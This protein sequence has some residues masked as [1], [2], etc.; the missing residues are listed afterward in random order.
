MPDD[1]VQ[2]IFPLSQVVPVRPHP[3]NVKQERR[4]KRRGKRSQDEKSGK[5]KMESPSETLDKV[6][7]KR[8][9]NANPGRKTFHKRHCGSNPDGGETES[10]KHIDIK[11]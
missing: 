5:K 4:R 7:L 11:V 2:D 8:D 10:A 3:S 1:F 9:E 6:T